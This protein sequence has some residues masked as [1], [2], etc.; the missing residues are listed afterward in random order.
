MKNKSLDRFDHAIL[1]LLQKD[2]SLG[3]NEIAERV[4]LSPTPCWRRIQKLNETGVVRRR[5]ALLDP[6]KVNTAVT[7][8]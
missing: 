8:L 6:V 3:L 5:V 4:Q 1:D 7:V 2:A